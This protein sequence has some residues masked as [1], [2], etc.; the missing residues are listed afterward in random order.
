ML[1][2]TPDATSGWLASDMI[3]NIMERGI[4]NPLGLLELT[5]DTVLT[6]N[7]KLEWNNRS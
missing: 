3:D 4:G 5:E 1:L 2:T 6:Y 7:R